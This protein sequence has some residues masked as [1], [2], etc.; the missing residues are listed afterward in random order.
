MMLIAAEPT[1][2][3]TVWIASVYITAVS[4]PRMAY[5]AG[6]EHHAHRPDPEV[7][8]AVEEVVRETGP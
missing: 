2:N 4:P 1:M 6:D 5:D 8:D 3:T 7:V